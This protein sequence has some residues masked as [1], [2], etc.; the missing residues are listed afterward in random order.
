MK[1]DFIQVLDKC[2]E[3][4]AQQSRGCNADIYFHDRPMY[5][6]FYFEHNNIFNK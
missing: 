1:I 4:K 2:M 3:T 5:T 6:K